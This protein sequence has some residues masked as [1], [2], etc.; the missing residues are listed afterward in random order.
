MVD[1]C[2]DARD[3][4]LVDISQT[5]RQTRHTTGSKEKD[6]IQSILIMEN[7][8]QAHHQ[9][10]AAKKTKKDGLGRDSNPGPVIT[11]VS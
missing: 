8:G 2:H 5:D 4:C 1:V 9:N 6:L 3:M 10:T 7:E 11:T